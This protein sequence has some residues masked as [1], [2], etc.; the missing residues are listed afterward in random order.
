[1]GMSWRTSTQ[2]RLHCGPP[3]PPRPVSPLAA[4]RAEAFAGMGWTI[5]ALRCLWIE[6]QI[7]P[8]R[9]PYFAALWAATRRVVAVQIP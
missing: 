5:I 8:A 2:R 4:K 6:G 3:H 1:M 9:C 7:P